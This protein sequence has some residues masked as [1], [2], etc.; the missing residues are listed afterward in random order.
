MKRH[1]FAVLFFVASPAFA[2]PSLFIDPA[3]LFTDSSVEVKL[4]VAS[5]LSRAPKMDVSSLTLPEKP[6]EYAQFNTELTDTIR[7]ANFDL[8]VVTA[9]RF[10][11]IIKLHP[12]YVPMAEIAMKDKG[13]ACTF[14]ISFIAKSNKKSVS[15]KI[16]MLSEDTLQ[17]SIT[18]L[19]TDTFPK[20][21]I[22]QER[23]KPVLLRLLVD[24]AIDVIAIRSTPRPE[25]IMLHMFS[26]NMLGSKLHE[27]RVLKTDFPCGVL[28]AKKSIQ[29]PEKIAN[30]IVS[31]FGEDS[32]L[33]IK[34]LPTSVTRR[35]RL[36]EIFRSK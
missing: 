16:G 35:K 28:I 5:I 14:G 30:H 2:K 32:R 33:K 29:E 3:S 36:L 21:K 7:R 20:S 13:E 1:I 11:D 34:L 6:E 25:G 17:S 22:I 4:A 8:S 26:G 10:I 18:K 12:S 19:V 31:I 15:G 24:G 27:L 23:M 9:Q